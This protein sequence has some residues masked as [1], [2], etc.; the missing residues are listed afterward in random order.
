M[1][2]SICLYI[3]TIVNRSLLIMQNHRD[4]KSLEALVQKGITG[5]KNGEYN[6][7]YWLTVGN[8]LRRTSSQT[9]YYN[10]TTIHFQAMLHHQNQEESKAE[11]LLQQEIDGMKSGGYSFVYNG[12][13]SLEIFRTLRE[14]RNG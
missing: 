4:A 10:A 13:K 5:I 7:A 1:T 14:R 9:F 2:S 6:V 8:R 3:S 11:E 12:A